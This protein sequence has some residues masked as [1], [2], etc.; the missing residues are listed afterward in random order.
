MATTVLPYRDV[1]DRHQDKMITYI[2]GNYPWAPAKEMVTNWWDRL[3][4]RL[5]E[6]Y[7][8]KGVDHTLAGRILNEALGFLQ[9][10]TVENG[11]GPSEMVDLG[12]HTM[13]LYTMEYAALCDAMA[14]RFMHHLPTD[15]PS[16]THSMCDAC[17]SCGGDDGDG[18]TKAK[19]CTTCGSGGGCKH[20]GGQDKCKTRAEGTCE[21]GKC[22][23]PCHS[24]C[25]GQHN[26]SLALQDTVN[27]MALLGPVDDELWGVHVT[28]CRQTTCHGGPPPAAEADKCKSCQSCKGG[29]SCTTSACA[30]KGRCKAPELAVVGAGDTKCKVCSSCTGGGAC[31]KC[32][33]N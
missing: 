13:I 15:L 18:K 2:A 28:N 9:L 30:S 23:N 4:A 11:H 6:D 32:K 14:G 5:V 7:P 20:C 21:A 12:W 27:A 26:K 19:R 29:G 16:D 8:H 22:N 17:G 3:V 24:R 1:L 25:D 10:C 31:R 33:G